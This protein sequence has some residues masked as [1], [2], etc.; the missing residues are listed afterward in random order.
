MPKISESIEI[1][2]TYDK[3]WEIV[4]DVDH[5]EKYWW[6]TKEVR[7]ISKEEEGNVINREITQNFRN[8]KITQR[9][10]ISPKNAEVRIEYLKGVTRGLKVLK[11]VK[12]GENQQKLEAFWDIRFPGIYRLMS[13]FITGHVRKGTIDALQR[14][15][16]LSESREINNPRA[17]EEASVRLK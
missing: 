11:V 6:G 8:S 5:E 3:V 13:P 17:K 7:N 14:I 15:K 4:S 1:N 10:T 16:D 9:V 2:S 12:V